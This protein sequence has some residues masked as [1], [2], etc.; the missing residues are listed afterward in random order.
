MNRKVYNRGEKRHTKFYSIGR[1]M[2]YHG[3][4]YRQVST[5]LISTEMM[6]QVGVTH[7]DYFEQ[8]FGAVHATDG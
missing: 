6:G 2:V 8:F 3:I 1:E 4:L 7:F 5:V